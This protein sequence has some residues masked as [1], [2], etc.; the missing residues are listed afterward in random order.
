MNIDGTQ[1]VL[2]RVGDGS[3]NYFF[4]NGTPYGLKERAI[5]DYLPESE[6]VKNNSYHQYEMQMDFTKE[7]FENAINNSKIYDIDEKEEL[8]DVLNKYY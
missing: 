3:G 6:I 2:D 7:Y 4:T 5:G 1:K 8:L